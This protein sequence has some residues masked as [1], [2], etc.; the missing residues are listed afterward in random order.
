VIE[1]KLG[2]KPEQFD[3]QFLAWLDKQVRPTVEGYEKW[4]SSMKS[5]AA[6][7]RSKNHDAV[8]EQGKATISIYP[9]FVEGQSAYEAVADAFFAKGDR[10]SARKQLEQYSKAGGRNPETLMKL[11]KWQQEAGDRKSAIHTLERLIY[12]YPI[13]E[14]MHKTLG[15]LQIAEGN[16]ES[17]VRSYMAV[18]ASN[19]VD[20]AG[21][22]YNLARALLAAK[23][24]E[25]AK[26]QLLLS[27]EAA[28]GFKPAQRML[29]ELS[30]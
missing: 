28:P 21:S 16:P 27:L 4:Q 5:L 25:E 22:R 3:T 18:V 11:A 29:L 10:E 26:E 2:M 19:G 13:G 7:A 8:I 15:D 20:Q 24:T 30:Q 1:K 17:A 23:R 6:A 12:I 9:D 14:E